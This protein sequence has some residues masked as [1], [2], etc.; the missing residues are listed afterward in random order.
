LFIQLLSQGKDYFNNL[1]TSIVLAWQYIPVERLRIWCALLLLEKKIQ[2]QLFQVK[3]KT[4]KL[5]KLT[6]FMTLSNR[7]SV[8]GLNRYH[9]DLGI[10]IPKWNRRAMD[11][12]DVGSMLNVCCHIDI[13]L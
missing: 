11:L 5:Q 3:Y 4:K 2:W 10:T 12:R 7:T 8:K 9:L 1:D 13:F 6:A